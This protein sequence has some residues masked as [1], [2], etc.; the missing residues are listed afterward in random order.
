MKKIYLLTASLFLGAASFAQTVI[1]FESITLAADTFDNGA[2]GLSNFTQDANGEDVLFSNDYDPGGWWKGFSFS[3]MTDVTT[4]GFG[5]MYSVYAG[6]GFNGSSNFAVWYENGTITPQSDAVIIDSF[7]VTNTTYAVLSML[8]GDGYGKVFGSPTDAQGNVDGTN[9]ED[10]LRLW[11][12]AENFDGTAKDS[13]EFY[14]ADYRFANNNDDYIVDTWM[15]IDLTNL[16]V[17]PSKLSFRLESTDNDPQWGIK[18]PNYIA[19]DNI[20]YKLTLDVP[21]VEAMDVQAYPNP[22]ENT[23][24]VK[25]SEGELALISLTGEVVYSSTHNGYSL[26]DVKNISS[27]IYVISLTNASGKYT[28]RI[29][30]K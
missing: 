13:V 30:V 4:P 2:G 3:N 5:N 22:V 27:G 9:G 11:V 15:N 12:I 23:L 25:G 1:D 19:I 21:T 7:K 24:K 14:M 28:D 17:V 26:I 16:S 6:S 10:Y 18:T 8:N 29:I 20:H